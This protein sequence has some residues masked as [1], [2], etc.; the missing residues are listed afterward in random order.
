MKTIRDADTDFDDSYTAGD[1]PY[2]HGRVV[3]GPLFVC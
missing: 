2:A 1:T 3:G